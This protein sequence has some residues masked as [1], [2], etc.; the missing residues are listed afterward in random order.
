MHFMPLY[1]DGTEW[2]G[3]T[4]ILA[5]SATDATALVDGRELRRVLILRICRNHHD[6]SRRTVAGAVAAF[7]T[8]GED[9]AVLLRPH[10][11]TNLYARLILLLDRLDGT[12]RTNLAASVALWSAVATFIRHRRLHQLHQVCARAK[13]VVRTFCHTELTSRTVLRHVLG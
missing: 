9:D 13:Y 11:M 1:V 10:C 5:R 7:H 12:G 6:G 8:I 3:R 2:L 4:K